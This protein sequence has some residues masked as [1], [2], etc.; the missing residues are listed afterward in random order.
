[1]TGIP[2]RPLA[3]RLGSVSALSLALDVPTSPVVAGPSWPVPLLRRARAEGV[4]T[5][6][7]GATANLP[8]AASLLA[9]AFPDGS[10]PVELIV[11]VS[12]PSGSR[13]SHP[14]PTESFLEPL[15]RFGPL[16]GVISPDERGGLPRGAVEQAEQL[17]E[18]GTIAAW[19]V[20]RRP[21]PPR[22]REHGPATA[23]VE[24]STMSLLEPEWA[25][26]VA[27]SGAG[28]RLRGIVRDPYAQGRLDGSRIGPASLGRPGVPSD[29]RTLHREFDPVVRL[30]FLTEGR[31][32]TLP[33]AALQFALFWPWVAT[34]SCPPPAPERFRAW[35]DGVRARPLTRAEV[36]RVL[37]S[38]SDPGPRVDR[39]A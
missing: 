37:A 12:A 35:L 16:L 25:A 26:E 17:T 15:A 20:E 4:T 18:A 38:P 36:D 3:G 7:L 11:P 6:D 21:T 33:D 29:L 23:P 13:T 24:I 27:T 22:D 31:R 39:G 2:R 5:F 30:G 34:V 10:P 1:M 9:A 8:R 32:R 14:A 19:A 28:E